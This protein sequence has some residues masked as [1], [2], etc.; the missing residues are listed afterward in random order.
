MTSLRPRPATATFYLHFYHSLL[1][2]IF[3]PKIPSNTV[4][5]VYIPENCF[6]ERLLVTWCS[7]QEG[8]VQVFGRDVTGHPIFVQREVSWYV[9]ICDLM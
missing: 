4:C 2:F 6:P 8:D 5:T 9:T 3:Y 1:R 7:D